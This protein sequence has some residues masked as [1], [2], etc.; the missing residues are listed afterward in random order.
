M[1]GNLSQF[2]TPQIEEAVQDFYRLAAELAPGV[3]P[4]EE[5]PLANAWAELDRRYAEEAAA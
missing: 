5:G 1:T 2:D 3:T 4:R